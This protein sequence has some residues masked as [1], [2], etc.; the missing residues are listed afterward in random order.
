ME[1][2]HNTPAWNKIEHRAWHH[3][4]VV[5]WE[6]V[7]GQQQGGEGTGGRERSLGCSLDPLQI[8]LKRALIFIQMLLLWQSLNYKQ[9][10][11]NE[12]QRQS[13]NNRNI[14]MSRSTEE[15]TAQWPLFLEEGWI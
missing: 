11:L 4:L 5:H 7:A 6:E 15:E 1:R 12:V 2:A 13:A 9:Q 8:H 10:A 3:A 14:R